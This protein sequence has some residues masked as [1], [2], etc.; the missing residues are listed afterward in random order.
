MKWYKITIHYTLTPKSSDS[1]IFTDIAVGAYL[2][3]KVF[4]LRLALILI[5]WLLLDL[6]THT[7][8]CSQGKFMFAVVCRL[9]WISYAHLSSKT[10][11]NNIRTRMLT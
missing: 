8:L 1:I 5:M 7:G 3:Q 4:L 9:T 11:N 2:S 6:C 10:A